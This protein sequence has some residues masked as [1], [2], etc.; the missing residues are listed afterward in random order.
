MLQ[1]L[2]Y[3]AFKEPR[4]FLKVLQW[5]FAICAFA[6]TVNFSSTSSVLLTCK[7]NNTT[8][9]HQL[10]HPISYTF[11]L[12]QPHNA[13][14]FPICKNGTA[15]PN[16]GEPEC[17]LV[18]NAKSD[19]QFF[20]TTGVLSFLYATAL[21][22]MFLLADK[23]YTE[24]NRA[25]LIDFFITV[26]FAVFW[27]SASSAWANGLSAVRAGANPD[28]WQTVLK[29]NGDLQAGNICNATFTG[30]TC[31]DKASGEF[32]GIV[33]SILFGFIN[34]ILWAAN[35]WFL[36]KETTWFESIMKNSGNPGAAGV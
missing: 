3:E 8:T 31:S 17:Y 28:N 35:L 18:G 13:I 33:I 7:D 36:Y 4:G 2:S 16:G 29:V 10:Y 20:V 15:A 26:I 11:D 5:I 14:K 27:L 24:N 32:G 21:I 19:S 9:A 30:Y 12:D 34:F 22:V 23:S 6:T 1:D 25:P